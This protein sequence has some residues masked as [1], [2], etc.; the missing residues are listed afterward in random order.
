MLFHMYENW[1]PH[2]YFQSESILE[3]LKAIKLEQLQF[4]QDAGNAKT[5]I[6]KHRNPLCHPLVIQ[7]IPTDTMH[8]FIRKGHNNIKILA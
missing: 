6:R 8:S 1:W 2:V 4:K 3:S 7:L 5:T